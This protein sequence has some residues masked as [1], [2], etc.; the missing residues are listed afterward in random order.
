M[1]SQLFRLFNEEDKIK[2]DHK[3][4]MMMLFLSL[5]LI[6]PFCGGGGNIIPPFL[7]YSSAA[8]GDLNGDGKPDIAVAYSYIA[9]PPPHPGYVA[10][11]LQDPANPGTFLDPA[12]YSVGNDP[13]SISIGDLT[14]NGRLDIFTANAIL[15]ANGLGES[16]VS[17]LLQDPSKPGQFLAATSYSTGKN[18]VCLAS[19]DLNDDGRPDLAVADNDGISVLFQNPATPGTFF[20]RT[21]VD[22]SGAASSVAIADL[23]NDGKPD[24][25]VANVSSVL[26]LLQDPTKAGAFS[27]PKSYG[28]GLQPYYATVG[29]LDGDGKLDIAVANLGS[30]SDASLASAA[31]LLQNPSEPGSFLTAVNYKTD[32]RSLELAIADL[33]RDGKAD[34]A[35]ANSGTLG[36]PCP[37]SCGTA[38]TSVSVLLQ[39]PAV[40]GQFQAATN[41]PAYGGDFII[42]VATGDMNDDGKSDLIIAQAGG[43]FI[44]LQDPLHP[45]QFETAT[46]I[47]R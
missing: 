22:I 4:F 5:T 38:G 18:P 7:L 26:V 8:V 28:A 46:A 27:A 12:N 15:N 30:R 3:I 41:Y 9:G 32:L 17:V 39:N 13:V 14:G 21:A 33:N 37:P 6:L 31:V 24:L 10:V 20:P 29:D 19:G 23:N 47:Q 2:R 43:V 34:L 16:S 35:V 36:G 40:Q 1:I 45:G 42:A 25:V 11:Y 44:R